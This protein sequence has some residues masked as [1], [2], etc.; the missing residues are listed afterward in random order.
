MI[1]ILYIGIQRLISRNIEAPYQLLTDFDWL[2]TLLIAGFPLNVWPE[3]QNYSSV[4]SSIFVPL[5]K[6]LAS[7]CDELP[8]PQF[9]CSFLV[10]SP[11]FG[12]DGY[13]CGLVLLRKTNSERGSVGNST[14]VS[15]RK[16]K[17]SCSQVVRDM[18]K[19]KCMYAPTVNTSD[20]PHVDT[21]DHS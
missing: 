5:S 6:A 8:L 21:F 19:P 17:V 11:A 9:T 15:D 14:S 12:I 16:T 18:Y 2:K 1:A 13:I 7:L 4:P 10:Y 3:P 20:Y